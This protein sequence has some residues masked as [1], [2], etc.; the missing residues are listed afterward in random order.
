MLVQLVAVQWA[1]GYVVHGLRASLARAHLTMTLYGLAPF[2]N[3]ICSISGRPMTLSPNPGVG[4]QALRITSF[5]IG[6]G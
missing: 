3:G 4:I 1:Q 2:L 5:L 6:A